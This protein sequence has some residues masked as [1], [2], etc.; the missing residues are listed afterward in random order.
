MKQGKQASK[1]QFAYT[2]LHG[3]SYNERMYEIQMTSEWF[4]IAKNRLQ[5]I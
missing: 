5:S 1:Y 4:D 2:L 3:S